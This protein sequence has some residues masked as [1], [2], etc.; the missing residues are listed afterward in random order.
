MAH[1]LEQ[2]ERKTSVTAFVFHI[3]LQQ[4]SI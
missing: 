4:F 2:Y 1:F 3:L